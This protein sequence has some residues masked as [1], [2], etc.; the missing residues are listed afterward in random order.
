MASRPSNADYSH[1]QVG[2]ALKLIVR[3]FIS[4]HRFFRVS[5]VLI[6]VAL[7]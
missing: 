7:D 6:G 4:F 2:H 5:R 1:C 3:C